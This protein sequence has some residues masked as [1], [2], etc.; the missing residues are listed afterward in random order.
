[1][2]VELSNGKK[3]IEVV[4]EGFADSWSEQLVSNGVTPTTPIYIK[5]SSDPVVVYASFEPLTE[6][7]FEELEE[8]DADNEYKE[9]N[10]N[11]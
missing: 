6:E 8:G 1:M 7:E 5:P 4:D 10:G 2:I 11:D 9:K 3:V